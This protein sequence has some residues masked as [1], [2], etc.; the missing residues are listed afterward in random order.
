MLSQSQNQRDFVNSS[1]DVPQFK[2]QSKD[3]EHSKDIHKGKTSRFPW[4]Q[5]YISFNRLIYDYN[6]ATS[7][8]SEI[9]IPLWRYY[10]FNKW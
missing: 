4:S 7:I 8:I 2:W 10:C 3:K 1:F 6:I 9:K 5:V